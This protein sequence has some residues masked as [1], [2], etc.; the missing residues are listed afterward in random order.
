MDLFLTKV[1]A[2]LLYPVSLAI[3]LVLLGVV[4]AW[5]R[6]QRVGHGAIVL[7]VAVL[8]FA[9][10]PVFSDYLRSSLERR[11]PPTHVKHVASADAIVLLG[12]GIGV[13]Q[14]PRLTPD[15]NSAADRVLHAARLYRAS[16]APIVI[17]SG[18]EASWLG[19][20]MPEAYPMAALLHE[21]GVPREAII[22]ET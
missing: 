6:R 5:C 8:W 19:S 21:W 22:L 13:A 16:K 17:A 11:F 20:S 15:L 1:V 7:A 12:G 14:S 2:Q 4:L 9:S 10:T 3:L 18:G